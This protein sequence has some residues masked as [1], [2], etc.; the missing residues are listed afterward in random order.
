MISADSNAAMAGQFVGSILIVL[1]PLLIGYGFARK[2]NKDREYSDGVRWPIIVGSVISVLM[3][4]GQCSAKDTRN[5]SASNDNSVNVI[6]GPAAEAFPDKIDSQSLETYRAELTEMLKA[7]FGNRLGNLESRINAE[8]FGGKTLVV[9]NAKGSLG[10][11]MTRYVG[12]ING[13]QKLVV[14]ASMNGEQVLGCESK[15]IEVFGQPA[16]VE[17]R[18]Q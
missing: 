3:L 14:C 12:I 18:T 2:L 13:K 4:L 8:R 7:E 9:F 16:V 11:V 1:V 10:P 17:A 5:V 6:D 15:V